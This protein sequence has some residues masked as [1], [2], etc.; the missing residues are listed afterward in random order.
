[1]RKHTVQQH[2]QPLAGSNVHLRIEIN[3]TNQNSHIRT[4]NSRK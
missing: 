2:I 4:V 1:M 3:N